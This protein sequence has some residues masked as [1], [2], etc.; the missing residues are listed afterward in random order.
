ME[1]ETTG[2]IKGIEVLYMQWALE[3][4]WLTF[5]LG[6]LLILVLSDTL[7]NY[8][9]LKTMRQKAKDEHATKLK[10]H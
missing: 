6:V 8:F 2:K 5:I 1:R 3:H 4:P 7:S 10:I 9:R